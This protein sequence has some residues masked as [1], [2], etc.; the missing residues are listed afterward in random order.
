METKPPLPPFTPDTARQKVRMAE[1]A[2]NTRDPD[3]VVLAG[4]RSPQA[5][6]RATQVAAMHGIS[7]P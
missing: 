7:G 4:M 3:R 1:D 5:S 6:L 2:W